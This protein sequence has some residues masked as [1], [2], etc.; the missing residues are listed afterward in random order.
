MSGVNT[1][2]TAALNKKTLAAIAD[3]ASI[4][5]ATIYANSQRELRRNLHYAFIN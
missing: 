2:Q 5:R 3:A 4:K 1:R